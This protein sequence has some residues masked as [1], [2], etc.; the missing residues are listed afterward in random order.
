MAYDP[1]TFDA[2]HWIERGMARLRRGPSPA[3]VEE[4]S[5][6]LVSLCRENAFDLV[7]L[8][9]ENYFSA[10][11][12]ESARRAGR[13]PARFAYHSHDNNFS[14]GILKPPGFFDALRAFDAVFTTKSQN[15][16]RHKA[17]GQERTWFIPSA[18]EPTV[19]RPIPDRD[20][21]WASG[22]DVGFVGTYDRSRDELC[23]AVGWSQLRAWGSHWQRSPV[24]GRFKDR[25]TPR[26]L[27]YLEYA[28]VV[29]HT[30]VSLGFL[31]TEAEDRHTQRTFEIP[32]CGSLQLAPRNEE[33]LSFFDEN[34]EIVCYEGLEE[35]R[36]KTDFY[37]R[38]ETARMSLA[39]RGFERVTRDR[40]TY[41]DRV[42]RMVALSG[43]LPK[44]KE[45]FSSHRSTLWS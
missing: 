28:D 7:F 44:E 29:S 34:E 14:S 35:L 19:H 40:H 9:S 38:N 41:L 10:E 25:I 45:S 30:R 43:A 24:Y 21:A 4:A 16:A 17:L 22:I 5:R 32:A 37:L 1:R 15:V 23:E 27:Y 39:R 6:K 3:R 8:M 11:T 18:Y 13:R 26:P 20:S 2:A 12:L 42:A 33:I 36:D 31:R